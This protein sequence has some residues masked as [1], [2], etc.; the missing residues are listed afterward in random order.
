MS[1]LQSRSGTEVHNTKEDRMTCYAY[2]GTHYV[3]NRHSEDCDGECSG[4]EP[5]SERHCEDCTKVHVDA[6]EQ[7][8]PACIGKTRANLR[9]LVDLYATLPEEVEHRG[10]ES[11]AANL[12]GPATNAESWSYRKAALSLR[13]AVPM[14]ALEPDDEHHPLMVLGR[15]VFMLGEDYGDPTD[16]KLTMSRAVDYLDKRLG[17]IAHDVGQDWRQFAKEVRKCKQHMESVLHDGDQV[18]RGAPCY[19]CST[20]S[21]DEKAPKVVLHRNDADKTGAHDTWLCPDD[22]DHWWREADYRRWVA[23]DYI[24]NAPALNATDMARVHEVKPGSLTGWA[25]AKKVRKMGK[26]HSGRQLYSVEDVLRM[27]DKFDSQSA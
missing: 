4:C 24:K 8:C 5:C 18:E 22:R 12:Y 11:E 16:L 17:R 23:E 7:T 10:V 1:R 9:A 25:S 13:L 2:E 15:W 27:N 3:R 6:T 19:V 14:S 21:P 26:D 20:R